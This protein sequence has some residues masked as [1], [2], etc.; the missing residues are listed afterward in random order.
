M[1][2]KLHQKINVTLLLI[3]AFPKHGTDH[4][5]DRLFGLGLRQSSWTQNDSCGDAVTNML[6]RV[7]RHRLYFRAWGQHTG[8]SWNKVLIHLDE[9]ASQQPQPTRSSNLK[10]KKSGEKQRRRNNKT[11]KVI[12]EKTSQKTF[13][14]R[15]AKNR[16]QT[17][18]A[19]NHH[20]AE[21]HQGP[22]VL[23]SY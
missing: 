21:T 15:N 11:F 23:F 6:V 4:Q 10:L 8:T 16:V 9:K 2:R 19:Y 12:K 17:K 14:V 7:W 13:I 1:S 22:R 5:W 18:L 20:S 3:K